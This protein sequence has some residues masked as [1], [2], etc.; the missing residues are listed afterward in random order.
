MILR[1]K[2]DTS[3]YVLG[4]TRQDS[5]HT[6]MSQVD[7]NYM[8]ESKY[9]TGKKGAHLMVKSN[10]KTNKDSNDG[11]IQQ[12]QN[13]HPFCSPPNWARSSTKKTARPLPRPRSWRPP[14]RFVLG[15]KNKNPRAPRLRKYG[16]R[17]FLC[18]FLGGTPNKMCG[19]PVQ[20]AA[21]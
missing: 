1:P 18:V 8:T 11:G 17:T 9:N 12:N 7:I 13:K 16:V 20:R 3:P 21:L 10:N 14:D 4:G 2:R 6:C 15:R 19:F 5:K